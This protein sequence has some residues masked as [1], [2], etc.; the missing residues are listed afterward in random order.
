MDRGNAG[1]SARG[2]KLC[3][4]CHRSACVGDDMI[5]WAL[6]L[7]VAT[8]AED[9]SVTQTARAWEAAVAEV[10]A[11]LQPEH[12]TQAQRIARLVALDEVT[13]QNLW[14][15]DDP[16]LT[17]EQQRAASMAIGERMNAID[18]DNTAALKA[19][20]PADGWFRNRRDGRQVTHGAWLIVQ[21]SADNAFRATVL[22]A[23][24]ARLAD[25]DVDA[26]DFA[27]TA[28]RVA[29]HRHESQIYGSQARC[30]DG[31][32]TILPM[33]DPDQVD[34]R[35]IAIGWAKTFAETRGD[36]EIGKSCTL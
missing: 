6:A 18:A 12:P 9:P 2:E 17:P 32:L 25:G 33:V 7:L 14:R 1:A 31:K 11:Q 29:I 26:M 3:D 20:L 19:L 15:A 24:R 35:R 34:A 21:H 10:K 16:A 30:I 5:S 8:T 4:A 36:L 13:R 23:M 28:D 22:E 27:L